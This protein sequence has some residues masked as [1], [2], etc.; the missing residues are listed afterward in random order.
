MPCCKCNR[1]GSCRGCACVKA[2]R[3]CTNCLPS[4][5]GSC[6]NT[7]TTT[8]TV[9]TS[10]APPPAISPEV[11]PEISPTVNSNIDASFCPVHPN[12]SSVTDSFRSDECTLINAHQDIPDTA[13]E[14]TGNPEWSLPD[15]VPI[16]PP[17]S[18]GAH[19]RRSLLLPL[20]HMP[21][22]KWYI[23]E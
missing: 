15:P 13:L 1:T 14:Q 11:S 21:M 19:W 7:T 2:G 23:E 8:T 22:M 5:L 18:L 3:P 12:P 17:Y 10:Q 20:S 6:L 4:K 9:Q 16:T